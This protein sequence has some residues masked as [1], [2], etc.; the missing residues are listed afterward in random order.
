MASA[1]VCDLG[2]ADH[3]VPDHMSLAFGDKG[4]IGYELGRGADCLY[5]PHDIL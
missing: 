2:V 5:E 4:E 3:H 1:T